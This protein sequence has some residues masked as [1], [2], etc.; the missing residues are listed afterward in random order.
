MSANPMTCSNCGTENP[1]ERDT[2]IKC[3]EPLTASADVAL[4]TNLEATN[5]HSGLFPDTTSTMLDPFAGAPLPDVPPA[6]E[7]NPNIPRP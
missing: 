1:R 3:G 7:P 2:C 4:R 5:E 6:G